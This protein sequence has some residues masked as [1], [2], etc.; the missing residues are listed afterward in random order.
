M[1]SI[2]VVSTR[3]SVVEWWIVVFLAALGA[4]CGI[5]GLYQDDLI[6]K[7][8]VAWG[9]LAFSTLKLFMLSARAE[10][11]PINGWLTAAR[12]FA[13]AASL[14][15]VAKVLTLVFIR[16]WKLLFVP[17]RKRHIVVCGLGRLGLA[18]AKRFDSDGRSV[19]VI[20]QQASNDA[21][22]WAW[23]RGI[24]VVSGNASDAGVLR[25]AG[26][27]RA[28]H[29][30][31]ACGQDEANVAILSLVGQLVQARTGLRPSARPVLRPTLLG[32]TFLRDTDLRR[33][34]KAPD[35]FPGTGKHYGVNARSLDLYQVGARH[36]FEVS[37]LDYAPIDSASQRRCHLV[38]FGFG[39]MGEAL[40]LQAG[41]IGHFANGCQLRLTVVDPD[42][43]VRWRAFEKKYAA[44]GK[45]CAVELRVGAFD[46]LTTTP[47]LQELALGSAGDL[48]TVAVCRDGA[49]AFNV[50]IALSLANLLAGHQVR[51]LVSLTASEGFPVMFRGRAGRSV[52]DTVKPFGM[53]EEAC[54]RATVE[55]ETLAR[56]LHTGYL[57]HQAS[58]RA[59]GKSLGVAA[60]ERPWEELDEAFKE[61][62]RQA[63][64]HMPVKARALGYEVGEWR[65]GAATTLTL[66]REQKEVLARMEHARWCAERLLDGWVHDPVR[67]DAHKRHPDLRPWLEL[68]D[69]E[70][71]IDLAQIDRLLQAL[72]ADQKTLV[73]VR[74]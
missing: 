16:Q 64:D 60:S 59:A 26:V 35:A 29:V 21:V 8:K 47:I 4:S 49:D 5:V 7:G 69:R 65:P 20:E 31:A 52:Y 10:P 43:E 33:A 11:P 17:V 38:I 53:L 13:A 41:R 48:S 6:T 34:L 24:P 3:R 37:P 15:T 50:A 66:S 72:Q 55:N 45:V 22:E 46:Q 28:S 25:M 44:F 57:A 74:P 1:A 63:V 9:D 36:A 68:S 27:T 67:D 18:L 73:P 61:S 2:A 62:N 71:R 54:G 14:M 70:K 51:V 32:W 23:S 40:A 39:H 42:V 19:V 58:E 30:F 56:A 12:W